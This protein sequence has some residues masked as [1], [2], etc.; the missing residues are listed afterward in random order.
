M[1]SLK[2]VLNYYRAYVCARH[3]CGHMWHSPRMEVREQLC[4]VSP[5]VFTW[6]PGV[7]LVFERNQVSRLMPQAPSPT[8]P[9]L[10]PLLLC[11][12]W[13]NFSIWCGVHRNSFRFTNNAFSWLYLKHS[14]PI[15]TY[16]NKSYHSLNADWAWS[17]L[18][19]AQ[20]L[21]VKDA[22]YTYGGSAFSPQ[23]SQFQVQWVQCLWRHQETCYIL[24]DATWT[25][26]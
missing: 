26:E 17:E 24:S 19:V 25:H 1:T 7:R 15:W 16:Y 4:P 22:C 2:F 13:L 21:K 20:G 3:V 5:S 23:H 11:I 14:K 6:V 9:S 8:A 10:C 18:E 12:D